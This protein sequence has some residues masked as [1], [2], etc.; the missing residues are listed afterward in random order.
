LKEKTVDIFLILLCVTLGVSCSTDRNTASSR[1]YHELKTR[2]NLYHNAQETYDNLLEDQLKSTPVNGFELLSFY[3]STNIKEKSGIGGPFDVV[4]DKAEKAIIKH[5]I[6]SKPRRDP[7]KASSVNY[8]KWL[9]QEEFNP[10]IDN[11]WLLLGKAHVQNGD[12]DQALSVFNEILKIF[13]KNTD[14]TSEVQIWML[15]TYTEM[16]RFYDARNM[17]LILETRKMPNYLNRLYN[18]TLTQYLLLSKQYEKSLPLIRK[19]IDEERNLLKKKRLQFLIAQVY[20]IIEDYENAYKAFDELKRLNTPKEI[21]IYAIA[22]QNAI[23]TGEHHADSISNILRQS[24]ITKAPENLSLP[25]SPESTI[26]LNSQTLFKDTFQLYWNA[27][28]QKNINDYRQ[29][30]NSN[31]EVKS[32]FIINNM[33]PHMLILL[34]PEESEFINELLFASANFNFTN[35]KHRTFNIS[36]TRYNKR[37]AIKLEPFSS[38]KDVS[39][40]LQTLLSDTEYRTKIKDTITPVII[41]KDNFNILQNRSLDD[42]KM[43]YEANNFIHDDLSFS[44]VTPHTVSLSKTKNSIDNSIEESLSLDSDSIIQNSPI[45]LKTPE[46]KTADENSI[47]LKSSLEQKASEMME[48]SV[49]AA[50]ANNRAKEL[51]K[52]EELRAKRLKQREIEFKEREKEREMQIKQREKEREQKIREQNRVVNKR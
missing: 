17:I 44:E 34:L 33:S 7:A 6:S 48:R 45:L 46:I 27:H 8:R 9:K 35:F 43:F 19:V 37:D 51:R 23:Q 38:L 42:Y 50:S 30:G 41:S 47:D 13:P 11:V 31:E 25:S 26:N 1:A 52:R 32:E 40:Y 12:Y 15:R 49:D 29:L 28:L 10:F 5:S 22:Y 4:I 2:Y 39:N 36:P 21:S 14:L 20:T 18:E 24:L 16:N 3:P